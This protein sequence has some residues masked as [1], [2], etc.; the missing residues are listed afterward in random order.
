MEQAAVVNVK[1]QAD[2]E[3]AGSVGFSILVAVGIAVGARLL[4]VE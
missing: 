1:A 3:Y 4:V 2:L